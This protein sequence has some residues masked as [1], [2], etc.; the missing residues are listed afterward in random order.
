MHTRSNHGWRNYALHLSVSQLHHCKNQK[1]LRRYT[2]T[3]PLLWTS[4]MDSIEACR[5]EML[6]RC[7]NV[8]VEVDPACD[9]LDHGFWDSFL[10]D[11]DK[12]KL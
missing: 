9:V 3:V 8:D 4:Q 6:A 11:A 5:I 12:G 10:A 1:T 2:H 7:T